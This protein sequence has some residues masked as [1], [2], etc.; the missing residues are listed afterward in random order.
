MREETGRFQSGQPST[1]QRVLRI[2][3]ASRV[4]KEYGTL[5]RIRLRLSSIIYRMCIISGMIH[6]THRDHQ[7]GSLCSLPTH[8]HTSQG[9]QCHPM[10][11]PQRKSPGMSITL[12]NPL[13]QDSIVHLAHRPPQQTPEATPTTNWQSTGHS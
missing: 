13:H 8:Q 12:I 6:C 10:V 11:P 5:L 2:R 4:R 9:P 3:N 1:L 7:I